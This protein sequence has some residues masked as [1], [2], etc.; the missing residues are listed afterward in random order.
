MEEEQFVFLEDVKLDSYVNIM[1]LGDNNT[2][3]AGG[4]K[5]YLVKIS[6]I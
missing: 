4:K 2:Y 6:K 3:Y 5:G 1:C